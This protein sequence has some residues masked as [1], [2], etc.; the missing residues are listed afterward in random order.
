[1]VSVF[2]VSHMLGY[3]GFQTELNDERQ[4]GQSPRKQLKDT[5][6]CNQKDKWVTHLDPDTTDPQA[7]HQNT[8]DPCSTIWCFLSSSNLLQI[9]RLCMICNYWFVPYVGWLTCW[10]CSDSSSDSDAEYCCCSQC[11]CLHHCI[12]SEQWQLS[13]KR[14]S[15]TK[16]VEREYTSDTDI[17]QA[18]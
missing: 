12:C 10:G 13:V 15:K 2:Q 5:K 3:T 9:F 7:L 11:F 4:V 6:P 16:K 14:Q 1:M 17:Y 18:W 8:M